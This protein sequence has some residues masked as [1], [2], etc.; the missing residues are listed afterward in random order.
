[1]VKVFLENLAYKYFHFI[2][3][4]KDLIAQLFTQL[5]KEALHWVEFRISPHRLRRDRSGEMGNGSRAMPLCLQ[6]LSWCAPALSAISTT[7]WCPWTA[8]VSLLKWSAK[9]VKEACLPAGRLWSCPAEAGQ[10]TSLSRLRRDCQEEIYAPAIA[11]RN[12]TDLPAGRQVL[13]ISIR[14]RRSAHKSIPPEAG[15]TPLQYF[16][17]QNHNQLRMFD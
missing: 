17:E 10:L 15:Q 7:R 6:M 12:P 4:L 13:S 16:K 1:M 3:V 11:L 5:F 9:I 8:L 14:L 2:N